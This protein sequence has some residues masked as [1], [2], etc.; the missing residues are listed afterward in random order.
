MELKRT[1]PEDQYSELERQLRANAQSQR[2]ASENKSGFISTT[3]AIVKWILYA[4]LFLAVGALAQQS[5]AAGHNENGVVLWI[6][7]LLL[8]LGWRKI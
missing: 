7:W 2:R 4:L 8:L 3:W 5:C 1:L 6:V